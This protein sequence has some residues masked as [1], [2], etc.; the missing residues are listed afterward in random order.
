[1]GHAV[2][3]LRHSATSRKVAGSI[4]DGVIG[5]FHWHN[6]SGRTVAPGL[7]QPLTEMSTGN[8]SWGGKAAGGYGWS[9]HLNVLRVL[10][11]GSL[12]LP[13][14]LS[15]LSRPVMGLLLDPKDMF[16]LF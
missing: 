9:Y 8:I 14:T 12:S 3:Q 4:P 16:H 11:S 1:M 5:I 2:A 10:K 6:P 7:T 15:G 13:G